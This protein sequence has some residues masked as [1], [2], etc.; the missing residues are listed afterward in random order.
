VLLKNVLEIKKKADY[1][2]EKLQEKLLT[3]TFFKETFLLA[4]LFLLFSSLPD[5]KY[6]ENLHLL[7]GGLFF[8]ICLMYWPVN[9]GPKRAINI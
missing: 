9:H 8:S 2:A 6:V 4:T 3:P 7:F 5:L 1:G